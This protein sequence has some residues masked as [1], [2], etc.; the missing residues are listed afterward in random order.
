MAVL[1]PADLA[2]RW[3]VSP[4]TILNLI[5]RGELRAT[6]IGKQWRI[7]EADAEAYE[8]TRRRSPM[9]SERRDVGVAS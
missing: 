3:A 4:K 5:V 2:K 8:R 6:R 9:D 1:T 7:A